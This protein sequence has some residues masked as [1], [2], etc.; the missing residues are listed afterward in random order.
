VTTRPDRRERLFRDNEDAGKYLELLAKY[1]EQYGF[2]LFSYALMP[3]LIHLLIELM[4]KTTVSEIMHAMN[5]TYTKYYNSRHKRSGHLFKGRFRAAVVEKD[6]YL[7]ELTRYIHLVPGRMGTGL[8]PEEYKWSSYAHYIEAKGDAKE[9]L[10]KFSIIPGEQVRMYKRFIE[11]AKDLD[12]KALEKKVQ[13]SGIIGSPEFVKR[14]QEEFEETT[15]TGKESEKRM[16]LRSRFQKVFIVTGTIAIVAL[17]AITY[18]YYTASQKVEGKVE[19]MFQQRE[20]E[21]KKD[22]GDKYRADLVSYYRAT[23]KRLDRERKRREEMQ[24]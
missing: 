10:E 13:K 22:L 18:Y 2:K 3:S 12:L 7:T 5:S 1:K 8:K 17:S 16:V 19:D 14:V 6:T 15:K 11:E 24:N 23:T 9:V 21:L 4:P 20:E